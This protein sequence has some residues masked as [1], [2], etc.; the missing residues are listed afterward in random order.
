MQSCKYGNFVRVQH[1]AQHIVGA[2][3]V[4]FAARSSEMTT[5]Q[6]AWLQ[7]FPSSAASIRN[8]AMPPL[9]PEASLQDQILGACSEIHVS[10]QHTPLDDRHE[11]LFTQAAKSGSV[12][13]LQ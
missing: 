3:R 5:S 12:D 13:V 10:R 7:T 1:M 8:M 6:S 2:L 9:K 4:L 11:L